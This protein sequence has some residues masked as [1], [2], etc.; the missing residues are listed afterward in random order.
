M[1]RLPETPG[2]ENWEARREV[3]N[4][5]R[6]CRLQIQSSLFAELGAMGR[7]S[8]LTYKEES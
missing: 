1:L 5:N 8:A 6:D 2:F 4:R 3:M 7:A